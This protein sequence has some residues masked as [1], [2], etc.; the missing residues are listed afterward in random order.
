MGL[1]GVGKSSLINCIIPE[2]DARVGEVSA[3]SQ[4]GTHTTTVSSL[5][6]LPGG[7]HLIDSPGVR[8]F[9]PVITDR[10]QVLQGFTELRRHLGECRFNNCAHDSEPGCAIRKAIDDS[11][12]DAIRLQSYQHMLTELSNSM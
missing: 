12:I 11:E 6:H 1:S 5:Y 8:D 4:E 7:G 2:V 10:Q 9:T 3:A